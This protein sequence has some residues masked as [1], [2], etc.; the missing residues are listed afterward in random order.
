MLRDRSIQAMGGMICWKDC[1]GLYVFRMI[2]LSV[3]INVVFYHWYTSIMNVH[4]A[5][6]GCYVVRN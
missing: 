4:G 1:F 5:L 3:V 2:I 6:G